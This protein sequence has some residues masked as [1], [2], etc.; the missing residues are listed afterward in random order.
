MAWLVGMLALG[1][2]IFTVSLVHRY[3]ATRPTFA[4][5]GRSHAVKIHE[6]T[7]YLTS[8]EYAMAFVSHAVAIIA[9]GSFLGLLL[10]A[11]IKHSAPKP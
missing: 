10:K 11:R 9:V 2:S 3:G 1:I 5:S 7:V 4:E 8:R 6:R